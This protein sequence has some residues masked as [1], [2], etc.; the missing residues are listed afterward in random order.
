M[1]TSIAGKSKKKETFYSISKELD[2]FATDIKSKDD[3]VEFNV[4]SRDDTRRFEVRMLGQHNVSNILAATAA[5]LHLGLTLS[6]VSDALKELSRTR[7][8]GRLNIV[9]GKLGY[10]VIDDSYNSNPAGFQ[11]ALDVLAAQRARRKIL[12]TIGILELGSEANTVYKQLSKRIV[13]VCD[14]L[15]TTSEKL[16]RF[17]NESDPKFPVIFDRGVEKQLRFLRNEVGKQ[18][19]VLFEGPNL[20]LTKVV[21][22]KK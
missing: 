4:N 14:V 18:D 2:V 7:R 10:R 1:L 6:E 3:H 9:Q 15:V 20:Q 22:G 19:L 8:I 13:D 5:A 17:V 12:V 16:K 21:L 11:A